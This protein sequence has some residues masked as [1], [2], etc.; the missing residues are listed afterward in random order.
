[1]SKY[2]LST[3]E[4]DNENKDI[5]KTYFKQNSSTGKNT[6]VS[7]IINN[8]NNNTIINQNSST[9]KLYKIVRKSSQNVNVSSIQNSD[10]ERTEK[11]NAEVFDKIKSSQKGS[12]DEGEYL[13][14]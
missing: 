14:L 8:S 13:I 2:L 4:N 3:N 12:W 7:G 5:L 11:E 1:M 9:Q 6:S 10:R